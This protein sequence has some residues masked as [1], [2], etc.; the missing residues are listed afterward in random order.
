MNPKTVV[1]GLMALAVAGCPAAPRTADTPPPRPIKLV[2]TPPPTSARVAL[3]DWTRLPGAG[4]KV[5][6]AP[7]TP[8]MTKL[9]N[10][11]PVYHLKQ[12]PTPLVG[13]VLLMPRGSATDPKGKAGLTGLT[14]DMLD[15]GAGDQSALEISEELQRLGADYGA[16]TDVDHVMLSMNVIAESFAASVKLLANIARKPTL[17]AAEF[18]RRKD[19]RLADA[20]S[21]EKEPTYGRDLVM[22]KVLFGDGYGAELAFGTRTSL[23]RLT[24][25]DVKTHFGKLVA[26][27]SAA[28]VVVGGIEAEAAQS[29]LEQS[30]GDWKGAAGIKPAALASAKPEPALYFVDYPGASQSALVFAR[31]S[32]GQGTAEYFPSLIFNRAFGGAFTSR[33]NLNLRED[34]GYTY[35]A[36]SGFQRWRDAG[37]FSVATSV[38]AETTRASIDEVVKELS[39]VCDARPIDKGE[40]KEAVEGLLL[41]FPANFEAI[42]DVASQ[43]S[44]LPLYDRSIDWFS[45][46]PEQVT[47][48]TVDH[49]VSIASKYCDPKEFIIVV[50][51]DRKALAPTLGS[52]RPIRFY[53]AQGKRLE[54]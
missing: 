44:S 3:P 16:R 22:R 53:D 18:N 30:F 4:G 20:L 7:P 6:W 10:G 21:A 28:F 48:V 26:P 32:E 49:A 13:V 50:A 54:G 46:W 39:Q 29:A 51:G 33:I 31:R 37:Y 45:R 27:E 35:G 14:I 52:D 36:R 38:K 2:G 41:G 24:L 47:G 23:K 17:S 1:M 42:S 5:Q 11:I 34:K 12:G 8:T 43:F 25:A 40:R 19:Q 9:S 15:E